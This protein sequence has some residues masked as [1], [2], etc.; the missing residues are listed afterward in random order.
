MN[1]RP[2]PL[3]LEHLEQI[4]QIEKRATQCATDDLMNL[5]ASIRD[6]RS[7]AAAMFD[8]YWDYCISFGFGD[9]EELTVRRFSKEI[10]ACLA[11]VF[12]LSCKEEVVVREVNDAL[13]QWVR[14]RCIAWG[15]SPAPALT[16]DDDSGLGESAIA[17]MVAL[18][19]Q[20]GIKKLCEGADISPASYHVLK[21]GHGK[22]KIKTKMSTF[23]AIHP[24]SG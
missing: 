12:R 21:N 4:K 3:T 6:I 19:S 13:D 15:R 23:L 1:E 24:L 8:V 2:P 16:T 10:A 14:I 17:H 11:G 18:A 9:N 7:L 20:L 5:S 22:E